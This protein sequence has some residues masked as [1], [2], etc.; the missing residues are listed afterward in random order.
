MAVK[1]LSRESRVYFWQSSGAHLDVLYSLDVIL[2]IS[3][4]FRLLTGDSGQLCLESRYGLTHSP[5]RCWIRLAFF[6]SECEVPI[7]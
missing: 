3:W 2:V 5:R 6:D 1:T 7:R 4:R